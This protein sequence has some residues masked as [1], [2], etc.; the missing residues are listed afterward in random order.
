MDCL[1]EDFWKKIKFKNSAAADV[2]V[3]YGKKY[4]LDLLNSFA[5]QNSGSAGVLLWQHADCSFATKSHAKI[6]LSRFRKPSCRSLYFCLL[7]V[8]A[9]LLLLPHF[10]GIG[11]LTFATNFLFSPLKPEEKLA[12][13][14]NNLWKTALQLVFAWMSDH[15]RSL[16]RRRFCLIVNEDVIMNKFLLIIAEV[17]LESN[18][19]SG[20]KIPKYHIS[21]ASREKEKNSAEKFSLTNLNLAIQ[22]EFW[23]KSHNK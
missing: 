18:F 5:L 17:C 3:N 9:A 16:S 2:N 13:G 11:V 6:S 1:W 23:K 21:L 19:L 10:F 4:L 20:L 15:R 7:F 22:L 12:L 14:K 8:I